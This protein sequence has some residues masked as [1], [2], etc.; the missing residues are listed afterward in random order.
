[1]SNGLHKTT[2]YNNCFIKCLRNI[3][4]LRQHQW[5]NRCAS[6]TIL[7]HN[8]M[9][10]ILSNSKLMTYVV[11]IFES[12]VYVQFVH[13]RVQWTKLRIGQARLRHGQDILESDSFMDTRSLGHLGIRLRHGQDTLESDS[14]MD[15][16]PWNQT[17]SCILGHLGVRL[18]GGF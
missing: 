15:R 17:S 9:K 7:S 12:A 6:V 10:W 13:R 3:T 11:K 2:R 16:T 4:F 8:W 1:M 5:C 18:R 14:A